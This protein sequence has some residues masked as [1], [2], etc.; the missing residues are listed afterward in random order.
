MGSAGMVGLRVIPH[1]IFSLL[2]SD[3]WRGQSMAES[4]GNLP[5]TYLPA[6]PEN[7]SIIVLSSH[8]ECVKLL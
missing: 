7:I 6:F 5:F 1:R 8:L 4:A 2:E 3:S